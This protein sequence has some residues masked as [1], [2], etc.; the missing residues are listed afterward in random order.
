MDW[1]R[2][3]MWATWLVIATV[4]GV[5][6]LVSMDL[7][8]IMLAGGALVGMLVAFTTDVFAVQMLVS[9]GAAVA[10]LALLRPGMVKRLH[11]GPTLAIGAEALIG[12]RADVLVELS[13]IAPG[14]IKIEGEVWTAQPFDEDDRIELGASVEVVSI[15][16]ATAF[17][18]RSQT[19]AAPPSAGDSEKESS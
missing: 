19:P 4:F 9:I 3:N 14:R 2:D 10:L 15:K 18:V 13:R 11:A 5:L 6:E 16:G 7:I 12:K 17:V 1:F 8:L